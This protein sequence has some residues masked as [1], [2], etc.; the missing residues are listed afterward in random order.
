[1]NIVDKLKKHKYLVYT[2][3]FGFLM[4]CLTILFFGFQSDVD[5]VDYVKSIKY[6]LGKRGDFELNPHRVLRPG[7]IF[8]ALPLS[9]VF[10]EFWALTIINILFYFICLALI[11]FLGKAIFKQEKLGFLTALFFSSNYPMMRFGLCCL[12][13]M[14]AWFF[15]VLSL[16]LTVKFLQKPSLKLAGLN[17]FLSGIGFLVKESGGVGILFFLATLLVFNNFKSKDKF[18]YFLRFLFCFL[19]PVFINQA[20]VWHFFNYTYLD[21]YLYNAKTY[22]SQSYT[23]YNLFKNFFILFGISW[24]FVFLG[25]KKFWQE[26]KDPKKSCQTK[27]ISALFVPALSFFLWGDLTARLMYISGPLLALLASMGFQGFPLRFFANKIVLILAVNFNLFLV[28][29]SYWI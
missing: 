10:T 4:L 9:L 11:F 21:W 29:L 27:I 3:G 12:T 22:L 1:M 23:F 16:F 24:I 13:D 20:L 8:L 7:G 17:G 19:G 26:R 2:L 5:T 28:K 6:F 14:P 25:L 18:R 15:Y